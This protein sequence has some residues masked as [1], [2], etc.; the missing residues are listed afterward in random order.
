MTTGIHVGTIL[1][2]GENAIHPKTYCPPTYIFGL[3][4][5]I[6]GR[7]LS[8]FRQTGVLFAGLV[9]FLFL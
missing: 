7:I 6:A 5:A 3:M 1:A 2:G 4:S 8:Q 9:A